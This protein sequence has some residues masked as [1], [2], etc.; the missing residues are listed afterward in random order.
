MG[1]IGDAIGGLF[2]GG[3]DYEEPKSSKIASQIA[4]QLFTESTPIRTGI[5]DQ[6]TNFT[7]G[8]FDIGTSPMWAGGKNAIEN[9]YGVA[10][11][12]IIGN[13]ATGGAMY[14]GLNDLEATRAGSFTDLISNIQNDMFNKSY[15]IAT[16]TPQTSMQGLLGS[17]NA[18]TN[19]MQAQAQADAGKSQMM[20]GLGQ[21]LG[22][23]LAS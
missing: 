2:G 18:S 15:G 11:E 16:N 13:T 23:F 9:Q 17:A 8:N 5:I 12:N 10:R 14:Q 3:D 4:Q 7:G 21:G 1:S 19:A 20:G 6:L 22:M